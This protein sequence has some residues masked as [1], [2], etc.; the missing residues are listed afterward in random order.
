MESTGKSRCYLF[1]AV[2]GLIVPEQAASR[3]LHNQIL[4]SASKKSGARSI[5]RPGKRKSARSIAAFASRWAVPATTH[6][7][8]V[9]NRHVSAS[10]VIQ[11][12]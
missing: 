3:K 4:V 5:P 7:G 10:G 2:F 6:A 12:S 9:P 8:C 1:M 11:P